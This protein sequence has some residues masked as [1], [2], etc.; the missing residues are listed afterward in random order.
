MFDPYP[1]VLPT[2][3][4]STTKHLPRSSFSQ[5][6]LMVSMELVM[7]MFTFFVDKACDR[8]PSS[9]I[10]ANTALRP[11]LPFWMCG[12]LLMWVKVVVFFNVQATAKSQG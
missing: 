12:I 9:W 3:V 6:S 2:I 4:L 5:N 7:L 8:L 10:L 11:R 1:K